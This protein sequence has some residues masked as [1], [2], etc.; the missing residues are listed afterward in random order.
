MPLPILYSYR[1][2]P[3]AMRA[4]MALKYANINVEIREI[5]L[6]EKPA[7]MLIA[8]P[9]GTVPV[10]VLQDGKVLEQSLDI[11]Y[12][13]LQQRD[14][15]GWLTADKPLTQRLIAENDGSFKQALDKYKYA[16]RFPEQSVEFYRAQAEV[17]L[18]KLERLLAKSVFLLGDKVSLADIALFPFI[19]QFSGVDPVWFEAVAYLKLKAWL[20]QLVDSELF[21]DIM[22]KR[23][24][25]R[26]KQA[27]LIT[28]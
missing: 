1:R 13:A 23:P 9:K 2:C 14:I 24:T 11:I 18:Q 19:R 12:W 25:Y 15:D 27:V 6:K 4:R 26:G 7:E 5:A 22:Q 3:Y 17:F 21:V 8:S 20:K 10:L 28:D 16:I